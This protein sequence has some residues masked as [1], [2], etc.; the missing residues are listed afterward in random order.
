MILTSAKFVKGTYMMTWYITWHIGDPS[1]TTWIGVGSQISS[2]SNRVLQ[3]QYRHIYHLKT[4]GKRSLEHAL[5]W[6]CKCK[7]K[8]WNT[9]KTTYS[10]CIWYKFHRPTWGNCFVYGTKHKDRESK[11]LRH[12]WR[13]P[14]LETHTRYK[15]VPCQQVQSGIIAE[16]L[17]AKLSLR[18]VWLQS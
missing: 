3:Q 16:G 4:G 8:N 14:Q 15:G 6:S 12:L 7:N 13:T 1:P 10:R 11:S 9:Y 18:G 17:R 5:S 2:H